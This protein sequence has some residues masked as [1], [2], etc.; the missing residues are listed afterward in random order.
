MHFAANGV[1]SALTG[2]GGTSRRPSTRTMATYSIVTKDNHYGGL[3]SYCD[4]RCFCPRPTASIPPIPRRTS[5]RSSTPPCTSSGASEHEHAE[6]PA[7]C[8]RKR[9]LRQRTPA[10]VRVVRERVR[11]RR[12]GVVYANSEDGNLYAISQGGTLKQEIFQQL[13]IGAAYTPTS[14]GTDGRIYRK[15][16]GICS[17]SASSRRL[18][19]HGRDDHIPPRQFRN[20]RQSINVSQLD[21]D[22]KHCAWTKS[23]ALG[24]QRL[25]LWDQ[26]F[27]P[28]CRVCTQGSKGLWIEVGGTLSTWGSRG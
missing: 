7:R 21:A 9:D 2:S 8:G 13:A 3:G 5:S 15:T 4:E 14:I 20:N 6:L 10:R 1:T 28:I 17:L 12:N 16:P 23:Q 26:M 24:R 18:R 11:H 19:P 25:H 27:T 22:R